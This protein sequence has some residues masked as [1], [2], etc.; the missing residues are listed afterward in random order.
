MSDAFTDDLLA[1]L[2]ALRRFALSLA[3]A[4]DVADDLV[5]IT[6]EKALAARDRYDPSI[7]LNAW[8]F[9]ILRNAWIDMG[10][11]TRTRGAETDIADT[12]EAATTDGR[13]ETEARLMLDSTL[14]AMARLSEDHRTVL[15]LVCMEEMSYAEA[16]AV[17]DIPRGTVMSRL[18]RA[19][20]ALA[21]ELGIDTAPGA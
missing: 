10:R 15:A 1:A 19:R 12:P 14:A 7:P 3:R 6:V 20:L 5:Q 21:A 13:R 8:L 16:A 11:R 4:G 2:P 18:A 17:L 9:R